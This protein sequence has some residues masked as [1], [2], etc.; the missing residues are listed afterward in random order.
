MV[1]HDDVLL[2]AAHAA[3]RDG[4]GAGAVALRVAL[5]EGAGEGGRGW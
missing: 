2:G 3:Q 1:V 4:P 5:V